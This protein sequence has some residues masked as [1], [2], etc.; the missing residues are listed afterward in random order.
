VRRLTQLARR[1]TQL[2]A[3]I[4]ATR[5]EMR[6]NLSGARKDIAFAGFGILV[7]RFFAKHPVL[8]ALTV[9]ALAVSRKDAILSQLGL[10]GLFSGTRPP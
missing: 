7:T 2:I 3:Q 4:D 1:R 10:K 8:R 9:I 6:G 5:R